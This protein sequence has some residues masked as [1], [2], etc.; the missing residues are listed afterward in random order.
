MSWKVEFGQPP[1]EW[2]V[3]KH[4]ARTISEIWA[5]SVRDKTRWTRETVADG[6]IKI[7]VARMVSAI[8]EISI[9]N[10]Y[11]PKDFSLV[12]YGGAGP[13]HAA[14]IANEMEIPSVIVPF[15]QDISPRSDAL[16]PIYGKPLRKVAVLSWS[17]RAGKI[18]KRK[19]MKWRS[20]RWHH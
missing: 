19:C 8:K 13:M 14:F 17:R 20:W 11:D 10:G 6:I 1:C 3:A 2:I 7:A 9:S 12:A 16:V 18:L 15:A 5:V 4:G